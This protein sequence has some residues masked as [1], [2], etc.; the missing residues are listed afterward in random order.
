MTTIALIRHGETNWNLEERIQG[1]RDIP[2]NEAGRKQAEALAER[3]KREDWDRI[4]SSDLLRAKETAEIIA[5]KTGIPLLR[6]DVRLREKSYGKLEGTTAD[7]RIA[8]WGKR[9]N[10]LEY[11]VESNESAKRR[12]SELVDDVTQE[13][14]GQ[15]IV[16][17]SHGGLLHQ[18]IK[19]KF[20]LDYSGKIH[21]TSLS[22]FHE[23]ERVWKCLLF[24]CKAHLEK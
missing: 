23:Q 13:F 17:V 24:N 14:R 20:S 10:T 19:S 4:I 9:W 16:I 15:R 18:L 8:Q 11:G 6:V 3:L 5:I 1:Q 21:N 22:I 2:L 12:A 7:E